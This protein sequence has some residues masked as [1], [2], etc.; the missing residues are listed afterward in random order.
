MSTIPTFPIAL[1]INARRIPVR[2]TIREASE[3]EVQGVD[4]RVLSKAKTVTVLW[5]QVVLNKWGEAEPVEIEDPLGIRSALFRELKA[6]WAA[7]AVVKI[8]DE[9]GAW[10]VDPVWDARDEQRHTYAKGTF[11]T[12]T[13]GHRYL[14][15][16]QVRG[17][18]LDDVK[19]ET[20]RWYRLVCL[21]DD[22]S[23][24]KKAYG[25]PPK[26]DARPS[27]VFMFAA[28]AHF[29]NTLPVSLEWR[30]RDPRAVVEPLTATELLA[31]YAW[32]DVASRHSPQVCANCTSVFT[33]PRIKTHCDAVCAHRSAAKAYK[34]REAAKRRKAEK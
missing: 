33:N 34:R 9:V 1:E 29:T 26:G 17:V 18:A 7:E 20:E 27:D 8:L 12:I 19:R 30:G 6:G 11:A 10:A 15:R 24:L 32:A 28:E 25:A 4:G 14:G 13:S 3:P 5:P 31:A 22:P 21:L 23:K 16:I 2:W